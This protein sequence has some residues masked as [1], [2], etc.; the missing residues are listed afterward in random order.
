VLVQAVRNRL[1]IEIYALV[2]R[3]ITQVEERHLHQ[4]DVS[5]SKQHRD[6]VSHV[7]MYSLDKADNE[8]QNEILKDFLWTLYSKLEAVLR[9]H[10]VLEDS[11]RKIQAVS[12]DS[13]W[14]VGMLM[15]NDSTISA[16]T[17]QCN[18]RYSICLVIPCTTIILI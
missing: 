2:D 10:R 12:C 11:A 13:L 17:K 9:S 16:A 14:S 5:S 7:V 6:S 4:S 15:P 18:R 1:P 8:S 3:T